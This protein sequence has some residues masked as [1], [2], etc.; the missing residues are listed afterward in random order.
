M[1]ADS[2]YG[3][4]TFTS[5]GLPA[6]RLSGQDIILFRECTAPLVTYYSYRSYLAT[7]TLGLNDDGT[8]FEL[9]LK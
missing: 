1:N 3:T 5:N 7:T 9:E 8:F 6:S 4:P 2:D